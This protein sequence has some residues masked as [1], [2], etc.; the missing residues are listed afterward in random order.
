MLLFWAVPACSS[1]SLR[2]DECAPSDAAISLSPKEQ[3]SEKTPSRQLVNR[4]RIASKK[5]KKEGQ[6]ATD[7]PSFSKLVLLTSHCG[8]LLTTTSWAQA[9]P[10]LLVISAGTKE[11]NK[12][13]SLASPVVLDQQFAVGRSF[14]AG[15]T[16]SAV[17]VDTNGKVASEVAVG[18]PAVLELAG[19]KSAV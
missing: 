19:S 10:K 18:A 7:R 3:V 6:D 9:A 5:H 2:T 17:L 15:G 4:G 14:G 16:P 12:Q 13:M 1:R 11:A 8:L